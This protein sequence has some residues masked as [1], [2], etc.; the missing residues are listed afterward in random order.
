VRLAAFS[1]SILGRNTTPRRR[2]VRRLVAASPL[3]AFTGCRF[4]EPRGSTTQAHS[5]GNL[6]HLLFYVA[7][8]VAAIVYG[9]IIW[10]IIRYRRRGDEMPKQVRYHIPIEILYTAIP[11]L[12]VLGLFL[13]TYNTEKGVDEVVANPAVRVRVTAFQWQWRFEYPRYRID[14]VGTPARNPILVVPAGQTVEIRLYA[15]DV[16]HAFYVPGTLF[17][18]DAIP[19]FPNTFDLTFAGPGFHRGE[20]AEFCGLNHAYM[21]FGVR[22]LTPSRF[23]TWVSRHAG[24]ST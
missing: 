15:V 19:G 16:D 2:S 10:S 21:N 5:I 13:K 8:P 7:I 6:Y 18:R 22:V 24:T 14:V 20:C 12:I 1:G 4:G 3:L 9:L 23:R 11:V 17:K